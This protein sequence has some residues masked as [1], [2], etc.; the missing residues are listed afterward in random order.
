MLAVVL[1]VAFWVLMN[2]T[3]FG[4]DLRATGM[5]QTAAVASGVNVN[6]MV[7]VSMLLSGGI[8]GLIW[9]PSFFGAAHSY[10]TTFQAGLGFTG[11]AVALLGRNQPVGI[12]F[13]AVLFAF[14]NEQSNRLTLETDI[15]V[16]VVQITQGVIVLTVVVAYEVVRR[17]RAKLEQRNVAQSSQ[18]GSVA[19]GGGGDGM[20]RRPRRPPT[21][22][23]RLMRARRIQHAWLYDR[24]RRHRRR[25]PR[26]RRHRRRRHRLGRHDPRRVDRDLPDLDG[27]HRRSVERARRCRQHRSRGQM[28]LGT[29]GAGVLRLL[30]RPVDG[31]PRREHLSARRRPA[32]RPRDRDVRRRPHRL[33]CRDQHHRPRRA[34]FLAEEY[35]TDSKAAVDKRTGLDSPS[36]D[37]GSRCVR[38]GHRPR[39]QT[40]VRGLGHRRVHRRDHDQ[41]RYADLRGGP[42]DP[43]AW[44]LWRTS[45]GLRLRSCG[46]NPGA[47]ESL[48]VNVYRYKYIAVRVG[49]PGRHRRRVPRSRVV[50]RVTTGQTGGRGYIGLAAMIFG[51]WRPGGTAAGAL[52]FG[53]T[54]SLQLRD[55]TSVHALLLV[56]GLVL[57]RWPCG[58]FASGKKT[59]AAVLGIIGFGFLVVVPHDRHVPKEF[60]GM[61][62]YVAT[63][64]VL[65][66]AAQRL[67][68]PAADGLRYRRESGRSD[69]LPSRRLG[70]AAAR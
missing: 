13:G 37:H 39:E 65:A 54:D 70:G 52:L 20:R 18:P 43:T 49:R 8:A 27:R 36:R 61:T 10:G 7:V 11:I 44:I 62:P 6:K 50:E 45:F 16:D 51:N 26:A 33:R 22:E 21:P 32:S 67:R 3:R 56:V 4:F 31:H 66:L 68:M 35:F 57:V 42:R 55:A 28:I 1:G 46:E 63:L 47:A 48:G 19:Q 23:T 41:C 40:L 5:S 29:W 9:M 38:R 15:S 2:K 53:Y 17:Y 69:E 24:L 58:G 59:T 14:L 30:L 12:I 64:L 34:K 25:L 60:A